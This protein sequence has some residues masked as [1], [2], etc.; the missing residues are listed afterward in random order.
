MSIIELNKYKKDIRRVEV[1]QRIE[2]VSQHLSFS[3]AY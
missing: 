3:N 2:I 1:A